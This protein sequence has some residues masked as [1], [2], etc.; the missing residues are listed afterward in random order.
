MSHVILQKRTLK[1]KT[2]VLIIGAGLA[3]IMAAVS[4]AEAGA[5]VTLVSSGAI[6]SGSSF[7]PGT[8]GFGLVGPKD[9]KDEKDLTDTIMRVGCQMADRELVEVFVSQ[10][11]ESIA[12]LEQMG[13]PLKR[14]D[15]PGEREFIPC[16]DKKCRSWHGIVKEEAKPV[17]LAR[18]AA[19]GVRL[20]PHTEVTELV[21]ETEGAGG[22]AEVFA[23]GKDLSGGEI[24][25]KE[26]IPAKGGMSARVIGARAV[27]D[28]KQFVEFR[29]KSTVIA[30]GGIGGLFRYRLNPGDVTGMGQYLALAAGAKLVN[31]EFM[32][33]MPGFLSPAYGTVFNEKIFRYTK[34]PAYDGWGEKER[35]ELLELRSGHGP[36]TSRLKSGRVDEALSAA[37]AKEPEGVLVSYTPELKVRQPEFVKTYFDWLER[38]K[39]LTIDDPVR[40]G[41]FAHASNGGIRIDENGY[42]G[43][44]G[45]YAC[46]EATGGMHGADRLGGLS[47]ANGLVFGRIAGRAAA[48]EVSEARGAAEEQGFEAQEFEAQIPEAQIPEA[49]LSGTRI[50]KVRTEHGDEGN[51]GNDREQAEQLKELRKVRMQLKDRMSANAMIGRSETQCE[52]TLK[53]LSEQEARWGEKADAGEMAALYLE[54]CRL[55]AEIAV[56]TCMIRAIQLRRESRGSHHRSDY[57]S[58]DPEFAGRFVMD[59][60]GL[61]EII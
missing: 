17:F 39:H 50:V 24:P 12:Y 44:P 15:N 29:S 13:V 1:I 46:G 42:T 36:Y 54:H 8:W 30:S 43:V 16:F 32:Q 56:A 3:G 6:C 21:Q 9:E 37:W 55:R 49:R 18:L 61:S 28:G 48:R 59:L 58:E 2:D 10:I 53:W 25:A 33:M 4:A 7:Y 22:C 60:H 31:L 20:M 34:S 52:E 27:L 26:E 51:Y 11:N 23:E 19:L 41:I 45:L 57:P 5:E 38:E 40:V 47:T 14:A 35:Q